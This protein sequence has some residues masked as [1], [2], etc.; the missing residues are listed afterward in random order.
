[1]NLEKET[2]KQGEDISCLKADVAWLKKESAD[3]RA[4]RG[5]IVNE[6]KQ[7]KEKLLGRPTWFVMILLTSLSSI[8]FALGTFILFN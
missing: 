8:V 6:L 2:T 4:E 3:S 7:I 5:A 1:M